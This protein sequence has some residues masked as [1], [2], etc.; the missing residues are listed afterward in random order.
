MWLAKLTE[1]GMLRPSFV[2]PQPIRQLRDY[3]RMRIDLTRERTRYWQRLEK[4]LEDADQA[5]VGGF[6]DGHPFGARHAGGADRG[7]T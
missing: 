2:P 5:V 3:T 6:Q 7:R 1:K 4:L